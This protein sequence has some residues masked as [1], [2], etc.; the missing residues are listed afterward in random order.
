M[1][2]ACPSRKGLRRGGG[3]PD[4]PAALNGSS[5]SPV[6]S[7]LLLLP[8]LVVTGLGAEGEAHTLPP[9]APIFDLGP[10]QVNNSTIFAIIVAGL[11][12]LVSQ[13][14]VR[15]ATLVPGGL[16]NFWE[17]LVESLYDFFASILGADLAR[18]TYWFFSTLFVFILVANWAGLLP[19]VG[20]LGYLDEDEFKPFLRGANAD[21]NLTLA[22]SLVF[23]FLWTLW[24]FQCNGAKGVLLHIFP[25][26]G[27]GRG[28]LPVL[29]IPIFIFVGLIEIFSIC[30]RPV[31][32]TF[33]LYG[34][35]YAGESLLENII[36]M[37]GWYFG[38]LIVLPFYL[39]ELMVGLVQ[40]LVFALLCAVFTMLICRHDE[41]GAH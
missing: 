21:L 19:G 20:S 13:L 32:L 41:E 16:Q 37:G 9:A 40:A 26:T 11:I 35:I 8:L 18:R 25:V 23:F 3:C 17:F 6:L 38:W 33:R 27:L 31:A 4:H 34:N 5:A 39:L 7:L 22:M 10:L 1:N 36:H 30:I 12:I 28:F 24:A 14:A 15:N 29:L 2:A